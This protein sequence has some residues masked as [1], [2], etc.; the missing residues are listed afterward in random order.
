MTNLDITAFENL[1]AKSALVEQSSVPLAG[2]R[3]DP[4]LFERL[5]ADWKS[6]ASKK[7]LTKESLAAWAIIRGADPRRG[8]SP[9]VNSVKLANGASPW[10]AYEEALGACARLSE[11]ALAPWAATLEKDGCKHERWKWSGEHPLL[12]LLASF[13]PA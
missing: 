12:S 3:F 1:D 8:F 6:A 4:L 11:T 5:R 2:R 10:G 13:K 9:I 7:K